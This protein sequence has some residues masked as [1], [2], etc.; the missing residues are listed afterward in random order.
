MSQAAQ[1]K[2]AQMNVAEAL[3]GNT[4]LWCLVAIARHH[5]LDLSEKHLVHAHALGTAEISVRQMV[6]LARTSQMKAQSLRLTWNDLQQSGQALPVVLRLRDGSYVILA[7]LR[8]DRGVPEVAIRNPLARVAGFEFWTR[9]TLDTVWTGEVVLLKRR[10]RLTETG[11]TFGL[12]WFVPEIARQARSFFDVAVAAVVLQIIGLALPIFFQLVIDRVVLHQTYST[13]TALGVGVLIAIVFETALTYLR[14]LLL[15]HATAKIDIRMATTV[16][17]H[18]LS[19]PIDYFE[20]VSAGVLVNHVQQARTVREFMTGRLFFTLL[21]AIALFIFVPVLL[22]Y[23]MPLAAVVIAITLAMAGI[24][25]AVAGPFRR[26]LQDLYRSEA[27]RQALLVEAVHGINTVK[28]LSLEPVHRRVW[29]GRSAEVVERSVSVGN[30][31]AVARAVSGFLEKA[32]TVAVLWFGVELIF[33]GTLTV[34]ELVAFHMLAG[35][36]TGPLMQL[37]TLI[38]DYQQAAVSVRMM[39]EVMNATPEQGL[40]RGLQPQLSGALTFEDVSF[41]Y[42]TAISPALDKI[43]F[44]LPAG[45]VLGIVGR[46][47]SGKSTLVR[48]LQGLHTTRDGIIRIDGYDLREIDKIHLRRQIGVVLQENFLFRGTVRDNVAISRPDAGFEEIV[49]ACR[50]AGAD[51]FVQRLPHGYD[52]PLEEGAVNLSGGQKQRLAIARALLRRPTLLIL[53]E[54]T[55]ALDPES[56]AILQAHLPDVTRNRTTLIISHRLATIRHADAI[57]VLHEGRMAGFGTHEALL[58]TCPIYRH[59]W[60]IQTEAL[61]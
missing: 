49:Q 50:L 48:L 21:D 54:A 27:D 14:S 11:R 41:R 15:L 7:G 1:M 47:G 57:L 39:G 30:L 32:M 55:S 37:I 44:A 28:A 24:V 61:R 38:N 6:R 36:V 10:F 16:F 51:E 35:R 29:D 33:A 12:S 8:G 9:E 22:F 3:P 59:L 56:E 43:T 25:A 31:S 53:D 18:L 19:L 34:G 13:L 5:G 2:P 45:S 17:A 60:T 46:S 23:S 52:T 26:R 40:S 58:E 42:P 4:G 20:R